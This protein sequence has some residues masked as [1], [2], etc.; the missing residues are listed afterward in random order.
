MASTA[1]GARV[2]RMVPYR[3][4]VVEGPDRVAAV[5]RWVAA[6]PPEVGGDWEEFDGRTRPL[7]IF[8]AL[9]GRSLLIVD[10]LGLI[11]KKEKRRERVN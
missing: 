1:V 7:R 5:E 6:T 8:R 3:A 9:E 4:A 2:A 11:P 10:F